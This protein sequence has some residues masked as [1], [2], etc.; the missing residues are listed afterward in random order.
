MTPKRKR[1]ENKT[2]ILERRCKVIELH[3]Q[4]FTQ[5]EIAKQLKTT[6][7]TI[8]SDLKALLQEWRVES[9]D[10]YEQYLDREMDTL[11][12][13][14]KTAWAHFEKSC[15]ETIETTDLE[16]KKT[17]RIRTGC[18]DPRF[19]ETILRCIG[20]RCKLLGLDQ[21]AVIDVNVNGETTKDQAQT[22][23]NASMSALA[24]LVKKE[25]LIDVPKD[26]N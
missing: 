9:H 5:V 25:N 23:A 3:R 15:I 21:K 17:R 16:D 8:S 19:L 4:G 6:Q 22:L 20:A 18:G 26:I 2:R 12:Q 7:A 13:I 14:E 10:A 24:N 1:L 11:I